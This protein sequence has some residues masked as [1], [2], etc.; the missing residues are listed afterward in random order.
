MPKNKVYSAKIKEKTRKLRK[1]GWSL[2]EIS[3]KLNIPKNTISGWVKEIELTKEQKSRI[4]RKEIASAARGR[5]LAADLLQEKINQ[6]KKSIRQKVN[7]LGEIPFRDRHIGKLIC[8]ILYSCEGGKYP[9][10]RHLTFVNSDPK[11]IKLFLGL[12]RTYFNVN[13]EK[14]RCKIQ[15]RFDQSVDDLKIFWSNLTKIPLDQFHKS[16]VDKRTKHKPTLKKNYKGVC[17]I[18]YFD[19]AL[20][21]ELQ[22]IGESLFDH[23]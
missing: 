3:Q 9:N 13:E 19:T 21:F 15:Q 18:Q 6:W 10:T 12:L 20:Q 11:M 8:G 4:K 23:I 16:Y 1:Q 7:H 5:I 2:G 17:S 14:L 22:A